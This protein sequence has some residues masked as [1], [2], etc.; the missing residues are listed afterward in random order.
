MNRALGHFRARRTSWGWWDEWDDTALRTQDSRPGDEPRT[1]TW[2]AAVLT[3]TYRAPALRIWWSDKKNNV[4]VCF[5]LEECVSCINVYILHL[6]FMP[7]VLRDVFF[8]PANKWQ[9]VLNL[10]V[11][12]TTDNVTERFKSMFIDHVTEG[13]VFHVEKVWYWNCQQLNPLHI[14]LND[15]SK[16]YNDWISR[17]IDRLLDL[18]GKSLNWVINAIQQTQYS[19]LSADSSSSPS[20]S[21]GY[22][23]LHSCLGNWQIVKY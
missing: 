5:N 12:M 8:F 1:L 11:N 7:T 13:Y 23:K 17:Y 22:Q 19:K 18:T 6:Y 14:V 21:N 20:F 9:I 2:K 4:V 3:T 10:S 16:I 15:F